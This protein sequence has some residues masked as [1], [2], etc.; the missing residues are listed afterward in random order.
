MYQLLVLDRKSE[1]KLP[2]IGRYKDYLLP[3]PNGFEPPPKS[4]PTINKK[5][6]KYITVHLWHCTSCQKFNVADTCM[7][8][9]I[10]KS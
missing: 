6:V 7:N 9:K 10:E 2:V 8:N 1:Y 5:K 4:P 3:G